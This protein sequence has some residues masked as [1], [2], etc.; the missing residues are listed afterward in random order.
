MANLLF[1]NDATTNLAGPITATATSLNVA[2]GTGVLF[3]V[4]GSGSY[5]KLTLQDAAT[6]TLTEIMH[7]TAVNG[8]TF[9]VTRAQEATVGLNWLAGDLA[10]NLLT[11]GSL[12]GFAQTANLPSQFFQGSDVTAATNAVVVSNFVPANTAPVA[13]QNFLVAKGSASNTGAVTL[14]I[15]ANGAQI[16]VNYKDGSALATNDWPANAEALLYYT[17]GVYQF[18]AC[19]APT[20]RATA[21][22]GLAKDTSSNFLLALLNLVAD[23]RAAPVA[24]DVLALERHTDGATVSVSA[25]ALAAY[26]VS[27]I[28]TIAT[29]NPL[30][31]IVNCTGIPNVYSKTIFNSQYALMEGYGN[32]QVQGG[33]YY[34]FTLPVAFTT[35]NLFTVHYQDEGPSPTN[36]PGVFITGVPQSGGVVR[37][38]PRYNGNNYTGTLAFKYIC[39]GHQ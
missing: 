27:Y 1:A 14:Q 24:A 2:A 33:D 23:N 16:S 9:T 34:D 7:V 6:G 39:V 19:A 20:A 32:I 30:P 3:P 18:V 29:A 8:D 15:G 17:G 22:G 5:F 35:D 31:S 11:A 38:F 37:L 21:N 13:G 36:G 26:V 28:N 25:A 10:G 12:A 4:P